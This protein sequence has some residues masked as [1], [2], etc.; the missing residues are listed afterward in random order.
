M[1]LQDTPYPNRP[2]SKPC[3]RL[4]M[5]E[6]PEMGGQILPCELGFHMFE[7]VSTIKKSRFSGRTHVLT[8]FNH[9][10]VPIFRELLQFQPCPGAGPAL[11]GEVARLP[12]GERAGATT[13]A[14]SAFGAGGY[15][16]MYS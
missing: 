15:R 5:E 10:K 12:R 3:P 14:A 4:Q 11:R 8:C 1:D 9:Q 16:R 6:R 7:L 2:A 13:G